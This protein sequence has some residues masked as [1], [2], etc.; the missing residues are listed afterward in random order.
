M[1]L[2]LKTHVENQRPLKDSPISCTHRENVAEDH[3][4]SFTGK[5]SESQHQLKVQPLHVSYA[6]GMTPIRKKG[7]LEVGIFG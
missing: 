6:K 5:L 3:S 2:Q 4:E 1:N 7:D